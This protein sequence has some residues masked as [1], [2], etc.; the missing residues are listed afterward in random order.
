MSVGDTLR[1]LLA[2]ISSTI[3]V[4]LSKVFKDTG[5]GN[6][7]LVVSSLLGGFLGTDARVLRGRKTIRDVRVFADG[8]NLQL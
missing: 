1:P 3:E 4:K 2:G 8:C 5:L 6:V 7:L